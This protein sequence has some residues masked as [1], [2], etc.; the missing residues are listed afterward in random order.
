MDK[1]A[2]NEIRKLFDKNDC[3]VDRMYGCYVNEQKERIA[4]L[5]DSFHSLQ[6]EELFKYC[7]IFK[8][9]VSGKIGRT[10]FNMEFPLSEE[11]EGGHQPELYELLKSGLKDEEMV[12]R[13]FDRIISV[14]RCP[15][16]YLILLVHGVYDI[17]GRTSD[18]IGMYDAS[19]DVY[20]FME[21][22]ICPVKLLRDGLCYDAGE[23]AFFSRT[24]DWAVQKPEVGLLYPAFNERSTDIH[25]ALWYA[26]NDACRHEEL[27]EELLGFDPPRGQSSE[28]DL[29][30][31][32]I[33]VSL[34]GEY[35][36]DSVVKINDAVNRMVED[37]KDAGETVMLDRHDIRRV[38]YDCAEEAEESP[39]KIEKTL[40]RFD[41]AYDHLIGD[42]EPRLLAENVAEPKKLSIRNDTLKLEVLTEAAELIETK[43]IDGQEFL[44]IPVTEDL[45]VNGIRIRRKREG[46]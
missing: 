31:E 10:L 5:K 20:E 21:L 30:R 9:A 22:S 38:L 13:F 28:R 2:I 27:T 42:E 26:K 40:G 29:F 8:K 39:E 7:E 33:E 12:D 24:E 19:T 16:K 3:R 44:L 1:K 43:V 14:Y 36:Y 15:E 17:P 46:Q 41:E 6:D 18:G 32:V 11:K 25:A 35:D 23:K 45:T 4:D 34:G 37:G